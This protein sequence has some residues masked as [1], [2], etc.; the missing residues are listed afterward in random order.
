MVFSQTF[1]SREDRNWDS[2]RVHGGGAKGGQPN[3]YIA[4]AED[5]QY[6]VAVEGG[7]NGHNSID[8]AGKFTNTPSSTSPVVV[9]NPHPYYRAERRVVCCKDGLR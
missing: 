6:T 4:T 2:R 7:D 9:Q 8:N 1:T 3:P 5:A